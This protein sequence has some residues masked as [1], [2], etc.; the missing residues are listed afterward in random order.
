M[1]DFNASPYSY[2]MR[3]LSK[4]L[5]S[6]SMVADKPWARCTWFGYSEL[7]CASIDHVYVPNDAVVI[8]KKIGP[9]IG[10]DHRAVDV[11]VILN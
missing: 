4:E 6:T 3:K 8:D 9:A 2:D 7:L 10:S 11:D 5:K 1:G